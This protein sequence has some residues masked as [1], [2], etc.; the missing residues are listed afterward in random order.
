ME[1]LD[2]SRLDTDQ[3]QVV[4]IAGQ[5][6]SGKSYVAKKALVEPEGF[7]PI[8]FS[9][10]FKEDT[11]VHDGFGF[12]E[13]FLDRNPESRE[14]LQ[15]KGSEYRETFWPDVLADHLEVRVGYLLNYGINRIV[16]PDIRYENEVKRINSMG[17]FTVKLTDRS[18]STA[19]EAEHDSEQAVSRIDDA[20][21]DAEVSNA[22]E[23]EDDAIQTI[24]EKTMDYFNQSAVSLSP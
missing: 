13:T 7:V 20:L 9:Q 10:R 4:G 24:R 21:I 15:N 22:P 14:H 17:G 8:D 11:V 19:R 1:F 6:G 3:L 18:E 23:H 12:D 16:A 2:D 5:I